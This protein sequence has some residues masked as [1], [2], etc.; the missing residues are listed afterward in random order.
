MAQQTTTP[1]QTFYAVFSQTSNGTTPEADR[2]KDDFNFSRFRGMYATKQEAL[3]A[4]VYYRDVEINVSNFTGG[5]FHLYNPSHEYPR[6]LAPGPIRTRHQDN[7]A[8][9]YQFNTENGKASVWMREVGVST[10]GG[11][12]LAV[13]GKPEYEDAEEALE[14]FRWADIEGTDS[15]RDSSGSE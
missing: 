10:L 6:A 14:R 13:Q 2:D 11:E 1:N 12:E 7:F 3:T 15:E 8:F 9:G 5:T 4:L